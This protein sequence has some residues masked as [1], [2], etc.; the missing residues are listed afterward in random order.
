MKLISEHLGEII[1]A[2]AGVAL[3]VTAVVVFK[4]DLSEFF[5]KIIAT[6]TS[7]G[8]NILNEMDT[9]GNMAP[10]NNV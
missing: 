6:L 10:V 9:I 8:D 3:L 4:G 1:V 2:L 5:S 7:I